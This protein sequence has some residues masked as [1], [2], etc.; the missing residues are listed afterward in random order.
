MTTA[1]TIFEKD[2]F[3]KVR[4]VLKDGVVWFMAKDVAAALGYKDTAYAINAHC[5]GVG[6]TQTPTKGGLQTIKIIPESDVYRLVMR[7]QLASA[8]KFQDWV[9]GE[10]LP[11]IR[12][13]GG[14]CINSSTEAAIEMPKIAAILAANKQIAATLGL[15]EN[16]QILKANQLTR[17][18]TGFDC[19]REFEIPVLEYKPNVQ[20]HTPTILGDMCGL[21]A[22]KINKILEEK[23]FQ[24][25]TRD[26]HNKLVWV[27]TEKGKNFSRMFDTGK[28]HA[29]GSAIQQIK[30]AE[31][32]LEVS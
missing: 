10:V 1:M 25:E 23:G 15:D 32:V 30:W 6:E 27:V 5:K 2:G 20:Y 11:S 26:S 3:G 19:M 9:V 4:V 16:H 13:T 18:Q 22:V 17:Q 14:Y 29:D 7:S 12:K 31:N 8:E 28:I 24:K 21:S